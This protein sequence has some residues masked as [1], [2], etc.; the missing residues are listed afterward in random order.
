MATSTTYV[1]TLETLDLL[2][3]ERIC[4]Y[5]DSDPDTRRDLW[6]FSLTSKSCYEAA[7]V[8]R[9]CQIHIKLQCASDIKRQ[10]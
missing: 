10:L 3:L 8:Q 7:S 2:I 1:T 6:S 4:E 5:L 9:Y